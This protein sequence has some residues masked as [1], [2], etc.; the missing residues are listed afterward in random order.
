MARK[1]MQMKHLYTITKYIVLAVL[2]ALPSGASAHTIEAI[3]KQ[4]ADTAQPGQAATYGTP[5]A[6][7][8]DQVS[9]T[10]PTNYYDNLSGLS[11]EALRSEMRHQLRT[12]PHAF[13]EFRR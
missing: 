10:A 7:T 1:Q 3:T 8:Y 11:A 5:T 6:P 2:F 9:S 4:V 13:G 12:M